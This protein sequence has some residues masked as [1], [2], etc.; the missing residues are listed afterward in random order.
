MTKMTELITQITSI[1]EQNSKIKQKKH[2]VYVFHQIDSLIP[3]PMKYTLYTHSD[4]ALV[5][6][7]CMGSIF[8][9]VCLENVNINSA[10]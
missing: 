6:C 8:S 5:H 1:T 9:L 2:L 4:T 7:N 10:A 3:T